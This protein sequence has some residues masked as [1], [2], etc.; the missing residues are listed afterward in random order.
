Q[1]SARHKLP[2]HRLYIGLA[3]ERA[4]FAILELNPARV[5][6]VEH[7]RAR[8]RVLRPLRSEQSLPRITGNGLHAYRTAEDFGEGF[9]DLIRSDASRPLE[10]DDA[11]P[12][13]CL[14]QER[15]C[16][17]ADVGRRDHWHGLVERLQTAGHDN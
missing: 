15:G 13:P 6:T 4:L 3:F 11:A 5:E 7:L 1:S 2:E 14:L 17:M 12:R 9:G 8:R 10:F 16:Q